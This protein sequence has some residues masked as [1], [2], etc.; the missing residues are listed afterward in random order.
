MEERIVAVTAARVKGRLRLVAAVPAAFIRAL[1]QPTHFIVKAAGDRAVLTPLRVEGVVR[2]LMRRSTRGIPVYSIRLP[3]GVEARYL[4]ERDGALMLGEPGEGERAWPRRGRQ[5]I[6][7]PTEVVERWGWPRYVVVK[8]ADGGARI[9]PLRVDSKVVK[10]HAGNK[11]PLPQHL[12]YTGKI[13]V[14]LAGAGLELRPAAPTAPLSSPWW[15][16]WHRLNHLH[17]EAAFT[18]GVCGL[19]FSSL[20]QAVGHLAK[21]HGVP[22]SGRPSA[23]LRRLFAAGVLKKAP[24]IVDRESLRRVLSALLS[25]YRGS[26]AYIPLSDVLEALYGVSGYR[27]R[28]TA[29]ILRKMVGEEFDGWRL[30]EI[31]ANERGARL[32][33]RFTRVAPEQPGTEQPS[34]ASP[35]A[36]PT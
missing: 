4:V 19:W 1:G 8:R 25:S 36:Q 34:T 20:L 13:A 28:T 3:R 12:A 7:I 24:L 35:T 10:L 16:E 6:C 32:R 15:G 11:L 18:C 27:A 21:E 17:S 22:L 14:R 31:L 26:A 9:E 5:F 23:T 29:A 33:L 30:E 2:R